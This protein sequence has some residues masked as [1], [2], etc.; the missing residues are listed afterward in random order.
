MLTGN[1]DNLKHSRGLTIMEILISV[2]WFLIFAYLSY[3]LFHTFLRQIEQLELVSQGLIL[4]E[5]HIEELFSQNYSQVENSKQFLLDRIE[6]NH[7]AQ[8]LEPGQLNITNINH[9]W[10]KVID[11]ELK[12]KEK[13]LMQFYYLKTP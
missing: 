7:K 8:Y 3:S 2:S 1:N 11:I 9:Q 13:S 4:L 6:I 12:V 10:F 5:N